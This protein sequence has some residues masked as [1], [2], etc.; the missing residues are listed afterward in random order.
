MT[1]AARG[2]GARVAG[3]GAAAALAAL[4]GC[5]VGPDFHRP[6]VEAPP[7][8]AAAATDVPSRTVETPV[9]DQWWAGFHDAE[10]TSLVSRLAR[11]NLD[12]QIAAERVLQARA[13]RRI[14]A[15]QGL[16]HVGADVAYKRVRE[17]KNGMVSLLEPAPGAPLEFDQDDDMLQASWELDLFGR[18]RRSVEAAR[19]NTEAAV[20]DRRAVALAAIA[21]LAQTYLQLRGVQ[22]REEVLTRNVAA[23]EQR[24]KLVGDRFRNGVATRSDVAQADAQAASIGEDLPSLRQSQARLINA[25]GLLLAEPPRT[26]QPELSAHAPQPAEPPTVPVGLP[27]A[28]LR[29]R[30]DIR[31]AEASLHAATAQTGVA[32]AAFYPDVSLTG[33]LGTESLS[34][35]HLFDGVSRMFTAG[36]SL[37]LPIF[38]G[39]QLRGQLKLR[40]AEQREAALRY[41]KTVLQAWHDVDNAL[42]AYA[43]LQH[44]RQ[45]A[46]TVAKNDEISLKVAEDRYR[47]GV[48]SF[49]DVTVAQAQLFGAQET[50]VR[51]QTDLTTSLVALYKALG[52]GWRA[53]AP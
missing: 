40:R 13:E 53:V 42:T 12:L 17:S 20:Q 44:A 11:Q 49:I 18:V 8:F 36:P 3:A 15:A 1:G 16:P 38:E 34:T 4:C 33:G 52:G 39:G 28:L 7:H 31:E 25:L 50:L 9:D 43:E 27:S 14:A 22:A 24:R 5:T 46:Q 35:N 2:A 21:E 19:A 47:Q 32:V 29:R 10:L 51:A 26:L 48:E 23:A 30:P 37:S 45:D 6:V 41:R